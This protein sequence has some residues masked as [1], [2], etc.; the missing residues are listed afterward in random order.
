ME[1]QTIVAL[2]WSRDQRALGESQKKYG[3]LCFRL[4]ENILASR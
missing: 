1:D 2:Y 4:S 3:P